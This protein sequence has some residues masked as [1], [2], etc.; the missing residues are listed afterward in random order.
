MVFCITL[1]GFADQKEGVVNFNSNPNIQ[2]KQ[3]LSPGKLI[4]GINV[5]KLIASTIVEYGLLPARND[6]YAKKVTE[7]E[8]YYVPFKA[9][10]PVVEYISIESK[11]DYIWS[12]LVGRGLRF[13]LMKDESKTGFIQVGVFLDI[14]EAE[15]NFND[16]V[17]STS[18]VPL[19]KQDQAVGDR[20]VKW[21]RNRLI[22]MR[23]NAVVDISLFEKWSQETG[24]DAM[25]IAKVL[26]TALVKGASGV[27][28]GVEVR[29]P[30]IQSVDIPKEILPRMKIEVTLHISVPEDAN[31]P[32]SAYKDISRAVPFYV[33]Y[34]KSGEQEKFE[35]S[36][37]YISPYCTMATRDITIAVSSST[38]K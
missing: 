33:P 25:K 30:I 14:S 7:L 3:D 15:H 20:Y 19:E 36:V 16:A 8:G 31:D 2:R 27:H 18:I 37:I 22:F 24:T 28:R 11:N 21:N 34:V 23:D 38:S 5:N 17:F 12:H 35:Y 9:E 10:D 32:K 29:M 4:T 13:S 26:D 1:I 6:W